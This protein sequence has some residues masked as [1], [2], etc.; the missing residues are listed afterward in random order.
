[1][2]NKA[3]TI[4]T[5]GWDILKPAAAV[6]LVPSGMH[7]LFAHDPLLTFVVNY[8]VTMGCVVIIVAA[9]ALV[10]RLFA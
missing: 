10:C 1:M 7:W 9:W 5:A 4:L 6:A 3:K 2:F 8:L